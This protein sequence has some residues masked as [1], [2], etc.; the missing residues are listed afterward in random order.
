MNIFLL[1]T[2]PTLRAQYSFDCHMHWLA[3]EIAQLLANARLT[4]GL[5]APYKLA[6]PHHP[7]SKWVSSSK[8][9][10]RF[11]LT[12]GTA[13]LG[14]YEHRKGYRSIRM[15]EVFA[16][17]TD[18]PD[19]PDEP[20]GLHPVCRLNQPIV[21]ATLE[22]AVVLYREYYQTKVGLKDATYTNRARPE[23]LKVF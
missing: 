16:Q 6:Q 14:E 2:L 9:A 3:K 22:E 19:L 18:V 1:D 5:P 10:Y 4:H 11:A 7:L 23:W 21:Y 20:L 13:L 17:L 12:H 8:A 15:D